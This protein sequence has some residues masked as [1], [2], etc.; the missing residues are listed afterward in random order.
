[1][2]FS[3]NRRLAWI[4]LLACVLISV[5]L[6]GA[7]SLSSER[8]ALVKIFTNG[9]DSSTPTRFSMDAYLDKCA[10]SAALL[11]ESAKVV[12]KDAKTSDAVLEQAAALDA[13]D[14]PDG[15]Y[16]V[17]KQLVSTV[18]S[19]YTE[20]D[21]AGKTEETDIALNYGNFKGAC[22]RLER[23]EDYRKLAQTFNED[24]GAFPAGLIGGVFCVKQLDT[25]GW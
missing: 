21:K 5:F 20:L 3:E 25:F 6:L 9:V 16:S 10:E 12:L 14:G 4:V 13:N 15:R 23:D 18:N 7:G 17:Y 2:R 22:D 24:L 11:A 19:L 8:K 1:M